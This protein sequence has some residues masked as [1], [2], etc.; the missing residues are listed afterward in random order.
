[1]VGSRHP[2]S[3]VVTADD[4]GLSPEVNSGILSAFDDGL[5][6]NASL[7]AN[8]PVFE[9]AVQA[10]HDRGLTDR[11]GVHLNLTEGTAL[12]TALRSCPRFCTPDGQL[13][14]RHRQLSTLTEQEKVGVAAEL[15]AQLDAVVAVGVRPSHI[16][17]HHHVHTAW[18]L[19]TITI[20]LA[21]EY[22]VPA[23]RL[24]RNCGPSPSLPVQLYKKALN[25]RIRRAGLAAVA[26]FG[27]VQDVAGILENAV[28]PIEVMTH[29]VTTGDGTVVDEPG[30]SLKAA[31]TG[32]GIIER[33]TGQRDLGKG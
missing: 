7:M 24:T 16:D 29:P 21:R 27:S 20:A 14:W 4:F 9:P 12:S 17:S 28:G 30:G 6:T 15:R 8:M 22:G 1:M 2:I 10:G 19:A 33:M 32:L 11:L 5:I 13:V 26:H 31:V 18:P 3:V 25:N 23:I